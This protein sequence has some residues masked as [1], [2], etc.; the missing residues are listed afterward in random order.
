[1]ASPKPVEPYWLWV[2]GMPL[3]I[4]ERFIFDQLQ[5]RGL[6]VHDVFLSQTSGGSRFAF[7]AVDDS[8]AGRLATET[9]DRIR[10]DGKEIVVKP[11]RDHRTRSTQPDV[12][13][14]TSGVYIGPL[15]QAERSADETRCGITLMHIAPDA[16]PQD[17]ADFL[18]PTIT[19]AMIERIDVRTLGVSTLAF[20][21]LYD[22]EAA[23]RAILEL[24]GRV[25]LGHAVRAN[26]MQPDKRSIP[27]S[28]SMNAAPYRWVP[29]PS[30]RHS[31]RSSSP[32]RRPPLDER[33]IIPG[34]PPHEL[35]QH[36]PRPSSSRPTGT[37]PR[38]PAGQAMD[39][40]G[41]VSD[42]Q[43]SADKSDP[44][45]V[46]LSSLNLPEV[47]MQA[48]QGIWESA[49]SLPDSNIDRS[50]QLTARFGRVEEDV[51][52]VALEA[53]KGKP[54]FADD[55]AKQAHF[56][57]FLKAQAG[58]AK[59]YY[60]IF[61]AQLVH[62]NRSSELFTSAAYELAHSKG[63]V[64]GGMDDEPLPNPPDL[65]P[66]RRTD[67]LAKAV[68][69]D[70]LL[71]VLLFAQYM[72]VQEINAKASTNQLS[73][74]ETAIT[75]PSAQLDDRLLAVQCLL[76]FGA[77]ADPAVQCVPGD[78]NE[79]AMQELL[80]WENGG[81]AQAL[82]AHQLCRMIL[83][84]AADWLDAREQEREAS[85]K[86][87]SLPSAR[88][89]GIKREADESAV[90]QE[91]DVDE[92]VKD[93]ADDE[94]GSRAV[95]SAAAGVS[96]E[97]PPPPSPSRD[98]GSRT[99]GDALSQSTN[100]NA[101]TPPLSHIAFASLPSGTSS[102]DVE[103]LVQSVT[104]G[105][106]VHAVSLNLGAER[107]SLNAVVSLALPPE[108]AARAARL[109]DRTYLGGRRMSVRAQAAE[110]REQQIA[111]EA[112]GRAASPTPAP[113]GSL[114]AGKR[115]P[116][117]IESAGFPRSVHAAPSRSP[118]SARRRSASPRRRSR[119]T[120][121]PPRRVY[122]QDRSDRQRSFSPGGRHP[123][124]RSISPPPMPAS[125]VFVTNLPSTVGE[126]YLV[127]LLLQ[128]S[129]TADD[130]HIM[131]LPGQAT[132]SAY[133]GVC[134]S[135][136]AR[137]AINVFRQHYVGSRMLNAQPYRS[138]DGGTSPR[139][140]EANRTP[141][142]GPRRN[143]RYRPFDATTEV[144]VKH[145]KPEIQAAQLRDWVEC[146][147]GADCV[148][149]YDMALSKNR[150]EGVGFIE[151]HAVE[152]CERAISELDGQVW[153]STAVG[154]VWGRGIRGRRKRD[155]YAN[156]IP[157]S[158]SD[159]SRSSQHT[160]SNLEPLGAANRY[161][162]S[163][164]SRPPPSSPHSVDFT[165]RLPPSASRSIPPPPPPYHSAPGTPPPPSPRLQVDLRRLQSL[166]LPPAVISDL[167]RI[168][169]PLDEPPSD[170]F[171]RS[172]AVPVNF[173]CLSR[174]E[175][176]Q[177]LDANETKPEYPDDATMQARYE[178]FLKAQA[179]ES[180]D[181]YT[182]F[183]AQLADFN[184]TATTFAEKGRQA[185]GTLP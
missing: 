51:A 74:L 170:G 102:A 98:S 132:R 110:A 87:R 89:A 109:L 67:E 111:G 43:R 103:A 176:K 163:T 99:E 159:L 80:G 83:E 40:P 65:T 5:A 22:R 181:W 121:P 143:V 64:N 164:H 184:R 76:L 60:L 141:Y 18:H 73:P 95:P 52:K 59:D 7:V 57:A 128:E 84:Q 153:N 160:A 48:I 31:R 119:Q 129:I 28:S 37:E 106:A 107:D 173:A 15:R 174:R 44:D 1:M 23:R 122:T 182:V 12:G 6:V 117:Y 108:D 77:D 49:S 39:Q 24:D 151:F 56:D 135:E 185:A 93:E 134:S 146:H 14:G 27:S 157:S 47:D 30:S 29:E 10:V 82:E 147:L 131:Q 92:P 171:S 139:F 112:S 35:V 101:P 61:L 2:G 96:Q 130:V 149:S 53:N 75:V 152:D 41:L 81:R 125:W 118:P 55:K 116:P 69:Q 127:E 136:D 9:L 16:R 33:P 137:R 19:L 72:S 177:A 105:G 62:F 179:G 113:S 17:V 120:S 20:C 85:A 150:A 155:S 115:S 158:R 3:T 175:A 32:Q 13:V 86:A 114:A 168:W 38:Q 63:A 178:A 66:Q 91:M 144:I 156:P 183:Y 180:R 142:L 100:L 78:G 4:S 166:D 169:E 45:F 8:R 58:D 140:D 79:M 148:R 26:W 138:R 11:F 90:K 161:P 154:V 145:L 54:F 71:A 172:V 25:F 88:S 94:A 167:E 68:E 123:R 34:S 36:S 70:D 46:R 126:R 50:V 21:R 104:R 162:S 42:Q 133:V 165:C 124:S 97:E